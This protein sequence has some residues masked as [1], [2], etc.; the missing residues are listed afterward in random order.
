MNQSSLPHD[1][2]SNG[3]S[4]TN[5]PKFDNSKRVQSLGI[6]HVLDDDMLMEFLE[7]MSEK[8]LLTLSLVS[9]VFYIFAEEEELVENLWSLTLDPV[10]DPLHTQVGQK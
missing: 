9:H 1:R 5:V 7:W 8:D 6:F 10:E 2:K 3:N 4:T